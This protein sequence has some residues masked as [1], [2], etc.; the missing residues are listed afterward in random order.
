MYRAPL[1]ATSRDSPFEA[2]RSAEIVEQVR[3]R[4]EIVMQRDY[5]GA[6][7]HP[8]LDGI[9]GNFAPE[10]E[11]DVRLLQRLAALE[12][13]LERAGRIGSDF[14]MIAARKR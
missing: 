11:D 3:A 5:G 1:D 8:L 7:L 12:L 4:F 14:T 9:A 6:I 2:A 10:R 13:E